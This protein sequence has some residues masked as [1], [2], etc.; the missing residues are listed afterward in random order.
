MNDCRRC[1]APAST[2]L[3]LESPDLGTKIHLCEEC[4]ESARKNWRKWL[5]T[6]EGPKDV[7]QRSAEA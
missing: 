5:N 7:E 2:H 1:G 4:L 3:I 6:A